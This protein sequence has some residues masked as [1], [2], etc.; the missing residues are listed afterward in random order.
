MTDSLPF[1][2]HSAWFA[3]FERASATRKRLSVVAQLPRPLSGGWRGVVTQARDVATSAGQNTVA[4]RLEARLSG[5]DSVC[6]VGTDGK[7]YVCSGCGGALPLDAFGRRKMDRRVKLDDDGSP[8][9]RAHW[10]VVSVGTPENGRCRV[11]IQVRQNACRACR[12]G[13]VTEQARAAFW[14]RR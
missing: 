4:R 1:E 2:A 13:H 11:V 8:I 12:G 5:A 3:A 10:H 7:R 9:L 14:A 6:E